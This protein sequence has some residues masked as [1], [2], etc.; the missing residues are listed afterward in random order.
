MTGARLRTARRGLWPLSCIY[1]GAIRLRNALFDAGWRRIGRLPVPVISV[2]NL[3]VGGTGK[4]PLVLWLVEALAGAGHRPGVLARGYGRAPGAA[5]NDEGM[6]LAGRHPELLQVQNP[7]RVAGGQRLVELG[8]DV[9]VLDDGFQHRRL[10]RDCD[11]V[12]A[13]AAA[14][15]A[16]RRLLP[17]GDLREPARA[18]TRADA[19]VLTRAAGLDE[20]R[21][22]AA[23]IAVQRAAGRE[24]QVFYTEH[25]ARDVLARPSDEVLP[26]SALR[27]RRVAL[28]SAIARPQ[29]FEAS[30]AALGAEIVLRERCRDH[31]RFTAAE[32][33]AVR[34][35]V[36]ER[37]CVLVVT[38]KDDPKL[39]I[40]LPRWVLRIDLAFDGESPHR[41]LAR[42]LPERPR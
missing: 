7:D 2:G 8:A 22:A 32:L 34:A 13:D 12:C 25:R 33:S 6:L 4:T 26:L 21:R 30:V 5:L 1:G 20:G 35:R 38:E 15:F 18:L 11:L 14:P 9:V 37:D 42:V 41:L 17:A 29:S 27:G 19:V 24:L 40:D 39:P 3:S 36:E 16:D 28:L 10:H 31:H 23:R